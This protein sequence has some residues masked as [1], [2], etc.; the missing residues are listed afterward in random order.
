MHPII[1][2]HD[3]LVASQADIVTVALRRGRYNTKRG[4][5]IKLYPR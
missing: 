5:Y 1:L 2:M 3:A 4:G